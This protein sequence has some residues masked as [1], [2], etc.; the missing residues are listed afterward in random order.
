MELESFL[1]LFQQQECP[2]KDVLGLLTPLLH[3]VDTDLSQKH[4]IDE[5][6]ARAFPFFFRKGVAVECTKEQL[7]VIPSGTLIHGM[8]TVEKPVEHSSCFYNYIVRVH[9]DLYLLGLLHPEYW[10]SNYEEHFLRE[11]SISR[12]LFDSQTSCIHACTAS[13]I[14]FVVYE[15][16]SG[17]GMKDFLLRHPIPDLAVLR[18]IG[19]QLC[20]LV[21]TLHDALMS[22]LGIRM[23]LFGVSS[24][25]MFM[26]N[27]G[28]E[29][30]VGQIGNDVSRVRYLSPEQLDEGY[31]DARTDVYALGI[32]LC[33]LYNGQFPFP[34]KNRGIEEW[35]RFGD[36][37]QIPFLGSVHPDI[38]AVL[39]KAIHPEPMLR[40]DTAKHLKDAF[41]HAS[42]LVGW[43]IFDRQLLPKIQGRICRSKLYCDGEI[44]DWNGSLEEEFGDVYPTWR[45]FHGEL[46]LSIDPQYRNW[47]TE[48]DESSS[49]RL[50]EDVRSG[51]VRYDQLKKLH[52]LGYSTECLDICTRL[53]EDPSQALK[54]AYVYSSIFSDPKKSE[55][56]LS[57]AITAA[58]DF[59]A[60]LLLAVFTCWHRIDETTTKKLLL[61]LEEHCS[62]PQERIRLTHSYASLLDSEEDV[63]RHLN[64]Y[65]QDFSNQSFAVQY[66]AILGVIEGLG[67][68]PEL[69]RWGIRMEEGCSIDDFDAMAE[70]WTHLEVPKRSQKMQQKKMETLRLSVQ[71]TIQKLVTLNI[72]IPKV[73]KTNPEEMRAFIMEGRRMYSLGVRRQALHTLI[74][75][76]GVPMNIETISLEEEAIVEAEKYCASFVPEPLLPSPKKEEVE[77]EAIIIEPSVEIEEQND[78]EVLQE[79]RSL[80]LQLVL[81]WGVFFVIG[82]SFWYSCV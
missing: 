11:E 35:H 25:G 10:D 67:K 8:Y 44:I 69:V 74:K 82:F 71:Q 17:K 62:S 16:P 65:I 24:S 37:E 21:G 55:E 46:L 45:L 30:R 80:S 52:T 76:K 29:E 7:A 61:C 42:S 50:L 72:T 9:D 51:M 26:R 81:L 12:A 47:S 1:Q 59:D 77:Q 3:D 18:R 23:E 39:L 4:D 28:I 34:E 48:N 70:V 56:F 22:H 13:I 5:R 54:L 58:Q 27:F 73:S 75:E 36:R 38:Q 53:E 2:H 64:L 49:Q 43:F 31:L 33:R 40:Y 14:P 41:C 20:T 68:R 6:I 63:A 79:I 66:T 60:L 32:L 19:L 78:E 15:I 57:R